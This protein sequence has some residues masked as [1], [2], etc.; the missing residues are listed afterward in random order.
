M[1]GEQ[2]V[3]GNEEN[4]KKFLSMVPDE[5]LRA[6]LEEAML[7]CDGSTSRW[8]VFEDLVTTGKK[9]VIGSSLSNSMG[10]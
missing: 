2:D 8:A 3:L 4:V 7:K 6:K 1:L 9:V 5:R 10:Y